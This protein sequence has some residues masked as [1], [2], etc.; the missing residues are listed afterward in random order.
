MK[1]L[2]VNDQFFAANNGM[3]I[4]SRRFAHALEELGHE[5][6]V[7]STGE[8]GDTPYRM[9]PFH[10]PVF[11]GIITSQGMT[12]AR[13]DDA[14]LRDAVSWADVVHL[15]TPF[16]L[17]RHALN[18]AREM[19]KPFTAAF[20]V[21]PENVSSSAHLKD[22]KFVNDD[23]YAAFYRYFYRYCDLVHCPSAFI[24]EQLRLHGYHNRL[25]VISNGIDPAFHWCKRP[26]SPE[27]EG[28]FLIMMT[29]RYSIEKRQD[30][31]IDAVARSRYADRIRL[32][33]AGQGP[34]QAFLAERAAKLPVPPVMRFFPKEEL[35]DLLAQADLYVHA[36]DIEIEAMA[37]M[38]AFAC[39]RVPVIADS[40]RSATPQFALDERCLFPAGDAAALAER[41]D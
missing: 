32:V 30:V 19:G 39:G 10:L 26:K 36:A 6:R 29:G 12:F 17:E 20:H 4:S 25:V 16:P 22:V 34:R 41:I 27:Y 7:V 15:Q 21:Q 2:L 38:E 33:L 40:P 8:E 11:D 24:A 13:P 37:C 14:I 23:L 5:V 28:Q 35:I 31:L 18:I 3:T 1:I 9:E